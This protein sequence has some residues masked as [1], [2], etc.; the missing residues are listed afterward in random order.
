LVA[1]LVAVTATPGTIAPEVSLTFPVIEPRDSWAAAGAR[2]ARQAA[3]QAA[4]VEARRAEEASSMRMGS[5]WPHAG[6]A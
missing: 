4:R 1:T 5:S 6:Q 2:A 3:A